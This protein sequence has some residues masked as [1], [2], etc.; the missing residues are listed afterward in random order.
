MLR[1][2]GPSS[3]IW[4]TCAT[5]P[6][7]P[8]NTDTRPSAWRRPQGRHSQR[9]TRPR[10][11]LC[12]G[13]NHAALT[14][15]KKTA[16]DPI[17]SQ[18]AK[19]Q[20]GDSLSSRYPGNNPKTPNFGSNTVQRL[21]AILTTAS[22]AMHDHE[23]SNPRP[24][25]SRTIERAACKAQP[26]KQMIPIPKPTAAVRASISWTPNMPN[27]GCDRRVTMTTARMNVTNPP[28]NAVAPRFAQSRDTGRNRCPIYPPNGTAQSPAKESPSDA[29]Q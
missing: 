18:K 3:P 4:R 26:L 6:S 27:I 8:Y 7:R 29:N 15:K 2:I 22:R 19:C 9:G 1:A 5:T 17:H 10:Q 20:R 28:L 11:S 21:P 12:L 14:K 24:Y 16:A 25:R 13:N 23:N